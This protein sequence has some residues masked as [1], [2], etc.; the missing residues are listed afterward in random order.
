MSYEQCTLDQVI[1]ALQFVSPN[2]PRKE[3]AMMGMAIKS[4]FPDAFDVFDSWSSGGAS[5]KPRDARDAWKSFKASGGVGIGTLFAEAIKGGYR[6]ERRELTEKEKADFAR[7]RAER[8]AQRAQVEALEEAEAEAWHV[9]IA[10]LAQQ[11]WALLSDEGVSPY[12]G[13]KKVRAYGV[14]FVQRAVLIVV[15][16][17]RESSVVISGSENVQAYFKNRDPADSIRYIKKGCVVVPVYNEQFQIVNLQVIAAGGS[18]KFIKHGK[19]S[20]CFGVL[21]APVF[22]NSDAPLAIA[23]GYATGA[24]CVMATGWQCV[25]SWDCGNLAR[26]ARLMREIAPSRG[27]VLVADDDSKTEGNPG[28]TAARS[29]AAELGCMLAVPEFFSEAV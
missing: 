20:G 17:T 28:L 10:E 9:R 24:S 6:F 12:L 3:W 2:L 27:L 23:E 22:D 11:A 13:V 1:T 25:L 4:E 15:R 14:R 5:Y 8:M 18:K 7:E 29:V 26:V 19:K 16:E 21:G